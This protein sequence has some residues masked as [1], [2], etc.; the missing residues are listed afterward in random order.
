[1]T[2]FLMSVVL[3][4]PP[5]HDPWTGR[6]LRLAEQHSP[7]DA[8]AQ[9]LAR[10]TLEF[11]APIARSLGYDLLDPNP[12]VGLLPLAHC[13]TLPNTLE[14]FGLLL[15]YP[16]EY[17][18][19]LDW[20]DGQFGFLD[21]ILAH[22]TRVVKAALKGDP[23]F[24][25]LS[26]S[27]QV[28]SRIKSPQSLM[29]KLLQGRV[30]NDLLG[31]EIIVQ[32][33]HMISG[34]GELSA[35]AAAAGILRYVSSVENG[36]R[37]APKSFKDYVSQP[38]KSGYQAIH[39]TLVTDFHALALSSSSASSAS[40]DGSDTKRAPCQLELHIFTEEMKLQERRGPASHASYKAFPLRPEAILE[41]LGGETGV[42]SITEVA[43]HDFVPGPVD[44]T[45]KLEE[46]AHR[47]G[48]EDMDLEALRTSRSH[49]DEV[50][51][52]FQEL[53][54][55]NLTALP[56]GAEADVDE[57]PGPNE[58]RKQ[59]DRWVAFPDH[60]RQQHSLISHLPEKEIASI[61]CSNFGSTRPLEH[62]FGRHPIG[63]KTSARDKMALRASKRSAGLLPVLLLVALSYAFSTSFVSLST[64]PRRPSPAK[65]Q[66]QGRERSRV[67][68][69]ARGGEENGEKLGVGDVVSALCPDDDQ[70][71]PGTIEKINDD[72]TFC[73][74]WDDPEGGP[75][76]HDVPLDGTLAGTAGIRKIVIFKDYK[77]GEKVEAVFPD[78]GYWYPGEVTKIGDGKF[79]VK[80]E[81]PDGGPEESEVDPKDMKYPPI[82]FDQLVV[83]QKYQGTVKSVLDFGA[84]VDIGAESDGLLHISR[85]SQ[86]RIENIYDILSEG[87]Q[88]DVWIAG[89]REDEGK[90]GLTMVEGLTDGPARRPP[91]D[92]TPFADLPSDEWFTGVVARTAPF[93]AF[94]TVTLEDGTA[95]D[96]LVHVSKIKDGF[97]DNVDDE[98]SAGQDA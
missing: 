40:P 36:W 42:V 39:L 56:E 21:R 33:R 86:E 54:A 20:F 51:S 91:A 18:L 52:A 38:K 81:D 46:L 57:E 82:P 47:A 1:M 5:V 14:H 15:R 68:T 60:V 53:M 37:V 45:Q 70:W 84:F 71:Y 35:Y 87:Q 69:H 6:A 31:L 22:G 8:M 10:S 16:T 59:C 30:V 98:L 41:K 63:R 92:L 19:V 75:E 9:A 3:E 80:W 23:A 24:Q 28:K 62:N 65:S 50:V 2:E 79:T 26:S 78:D 34:K 61:S 48:F 49:V 58:K 93:G 89:K 67:L 73:V 13:E 76:T 94:V 44:A 96:G 32:P 17:R 97:V 12:E 43:H 64:A 83:G 4:L 88:V 72:S 29:K 25:S 27:Y 66:V 7:E 77:V 74:K 90:Y 55:S 11:H 85:I 95:A